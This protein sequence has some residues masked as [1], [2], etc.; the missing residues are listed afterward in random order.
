MELKNLS[1][2]EKGY[3]AALIDGEGWIGVTKTS[4]RYPA[5]LVIAMTHYETLVYIQ[6]LIGG[7]LYKASKANLYDSDKWVLMVSANTLRRLLPMLRPYIKT[8][9]RQVDLI[10]LY[11]SFFKP[12]DRISN[13]GLKAEIKDLFCNLFKKLNSRGSRKWG[14]F[15]ENLSEITLSQAIQEI[16]LKVHRLQTE[17]RNIKIKAILNSLNRKG[18]MSRSELLSNHFNKSRKNYILL[19]D[20]LTQLEREKRIKKVNYHNNGS[21][22]ILCNNVCTSAPHESDEI[23]GTTKR[24]VEVSDK[25]PIR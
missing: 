9:A 25:E 23:V 4:H 1:E 7:L 19:D 16:E 2:A 13:F 24:L 17:L 8:K 21:F 12:D 14:K 6:S 11:F 10:N 22:Y 5:R 15:K 20:I 3:I 18:K